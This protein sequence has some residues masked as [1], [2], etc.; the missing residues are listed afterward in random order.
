VQ[1]ARPKPRKPRQSRL[2][3]TAYHEAGHAVAAYLRNRR[4]TSVS[5]VAEHETLGQCVFGNQPGVIELDAESYRRTRDRIETLIMVA[6]AGVLAECQLTGRHNWRGAH[7]DLHDATDYA[8]YV[9]GDEQELNAYLRW[10]WER[11]RNLLS[12][13]PH[14]AAV[15]ALAAELLASRRIGERRARQLIAGALTRSAAG[16]SRGTHAVHSRL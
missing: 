4:F 12:A 9:T 5:I 2:Q 15:K 10:L 16:R 14:W 11:T 6:L 13:R 1:T 8:S 7:A 3:A